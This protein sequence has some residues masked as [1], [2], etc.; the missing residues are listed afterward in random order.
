MAQTVAL[1]NGT[2][3]LDSSEFTV[4]AGT[5]VTIGMKGHAGP[6]AAIYVFVK[7]PD[8]AYQKAGVLDNDRPVRVIDAP[9]TYLLRRPAGPIC[10][11]WYE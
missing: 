11:A 9:G 6:G 2:T 4:A 10:G 7:D 1:A 3:A 8:G 5:P